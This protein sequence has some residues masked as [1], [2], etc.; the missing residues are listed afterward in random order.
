MN[1]NL[2][3]KLQNTLNRLAKWRV[4]LVSWQLGTRLADDPECQAVKDHREVTI[5][6]R[7]E[8]STLIGLCVR[9]GLFTTE[10][11]QRALMEEAEMLNKNY[12]RLFPGMKATDIGM[13][14]DRRAAETMRN[15]KP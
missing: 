14:Y 11:Y 5:L 1:T 7:A 2:A 6:L 15:W 12:E 3:Q 8:V 4:V 10:D 13:Q 9:H